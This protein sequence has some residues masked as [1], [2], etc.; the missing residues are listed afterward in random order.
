MFKRVSLLKDLES[1]Q[2]AF[3]GRLGSSGKFLFV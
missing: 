3:D 1:S 2:A